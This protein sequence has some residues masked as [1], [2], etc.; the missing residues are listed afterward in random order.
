MEAGVVW[1]QPLLSIIVSWSL[2]K[3]THLAISEI[4]LQ[5]RMSRPLK[6]FYWVRPDFFHHNHIHRRK[7]EALQEAGISATMLAFVSAAD[8]KQNRNEYE[9]SERRYDVRVFRLPVTPWPSFWRKWFVRLYF[10]LHYL[11]YTNITVH[12]LLSDPSPLYRLRNSPLF[13]R[14][15]KIVTEYEGDA[16]AEVLYI[17]SVAEEGGPFDEPRGAMVLDYE[18][19]LARQKQEIDNSDMLLVVSDE[20]QDMLSERWGRTIDAL[21]Y[22]TVCDMRSGFVQELRS[23]IREKMALTN[24][25]VLV[26]LGGAANAWHRF[27]EACELVKTIADADSTIRFVALIRKT[28]LGI[29]HALIRDAGIESITTALHVKANEVPAYLSACDVALF[30]RHYHAMTRIV[31]SAKLGEYIA[32]GLPVLSTGAHAGYHSFLEA[33][34]LQIV[35][36]D[37]LVLGSDFHVRFQRLVENGKDTSRRVRLSSAAL[38]EFCYAGDPLPQYVDMIREINR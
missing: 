32:N 2:R 29:A 16:P 4:H 33:N 22:P 23:I 36:P 26:H 15:L 9:N 1:C 35:I 19:A 38:K 18:A 30:L 6:V 24:C 21:V 25:T 17:M 31:N 12:C 27:S 5:Q 10:C 14:R 3:A 28:D 11:V 34:D 20:H 7:V 8:W 13:R 37:S